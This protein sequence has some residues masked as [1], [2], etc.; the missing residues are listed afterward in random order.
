MQGRII[1]TL[2]CLEQI[3]VSSCIMKIPVTIVGVGAGFGYADSG[4]THHLME[5]I[6]IMRAF[7]GITINSISDRIMAAEVAER[8]AFA[9]VTNYVRLDR[10]PCPDLYEKTPDFQNGFAVLGEGKDGCIVSTGFMTHTAMGVSDTQ[11]KQGIDL[12]VIDVY[13]LP[14]NEDDLAEVI[15]NSGKV[16]TLEE[17]FLPGG[18]GSYILEILNDREIALP[19]KRLGLPFDRGYCYTYGGR[20]KIHEYYGVNPEAVASDIG[21]YFALGNEELVP[22]SASSGQLT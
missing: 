4:P 13:R 7:P 2:R 11:R 16:I 12:G 8:C 1:V 10:M 14:T 18:F 6:A 3:R 9:S 20:E 21:A 15:K 19:V 17:H 5:D 22:V